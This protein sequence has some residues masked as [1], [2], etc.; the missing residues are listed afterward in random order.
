MTNLTL[1]IDDKLLRAARMRAVKEGTSVNEICRRAIEAYA[2]QTDD[3]LMRYRRVQSEIDEA[4]KLRRAAQLSAGPLDE[5]GADDGGG[6]TPPS[7]SIR[8]GRVPDTASGR[9]RPGQRG[10]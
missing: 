9:L 2:A 8:R 3:R 5:P 1:S 6:D 10:A 4:Q 7:L